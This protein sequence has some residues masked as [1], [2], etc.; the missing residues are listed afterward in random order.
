MAGALTRIS[1]NLIGSDKVKLD[2]IEASATIDQTDDEIRTANGRD[3]ATFQMGHNILNMMTDPRLLILGESDPSGGVG[4][5]KDWSGNGHDGDYVGS[6]VA[7]DRVN[8][9][10]V[11]GCEYNGSSQYVSFGDH[12]DFAFGDGAADHAFTFS[13]VA[14]QDGTA[15]CRTFFGVHGNAPASERQYH[16]NLDTSHKLTCA[17]YDGSAN[18]HIGQA[19]DTATSTG[20]HL[21]TVTYDATE[22][23]TG[24]KLYVD[25][26]LVASTGTSNNVYTAMHNYSRSLHMGN[27]QDYAT[28]FS[29]ELGCAFMDG[30]E[31]NAAKIWQLWLEIKGRYGL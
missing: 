20:I 8:R 23:N 26:E 21:F 10:V 4:G 29:G 28:Y 18:A 9:G 12:D 27:S 14:E 24:I 22:A 13:W 6:M 5:C 25:G 17:L 16:I 31:W 2:G 15:A 7:G 11:Y 3:M 1:G 19:A 30:S